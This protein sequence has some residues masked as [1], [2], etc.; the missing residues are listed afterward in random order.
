MLGIQTEMSDIFLVLISVK[1]SKL[2]L[3]IHVPRTNLKMNMMSHRH[4]KVF[5]M[6]FI[7]CNPAAWSL[8]LPQTLNNSKC[9]SSSVFEDYLTL[10]KVTIKVS[11]MTVWSTN[12]HD[13]YLQ[14]WIKR[15]IRYKKVMTTTTSPPRASQCLPNFGK[16]KHMLICRADK[17][18]VSSYFCSKT[19]YDLKQKQTPTFD[20]SHTVT[21]SFSATRS[22]ECTLFGTLL[23]SLA[24]PQPKSATTRFL[25]LK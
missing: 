9:K 10:E 23:A 5:Y 11:H 13:F 4:E 25:C 6:K 16:Q 21:W 19:F 1:E 22:N 18:Y 20:I 8:K 2:S 12:N 24:S 15:I 17:V 7:Y 14:V 3:A